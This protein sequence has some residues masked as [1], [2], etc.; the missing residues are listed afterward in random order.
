VKSGNSRIKNR[1]FNRIL[2]IKLRAIGDIVLCTPVFPNIKNAFPDSTVDVMVEEASSPLLQNNRFI[3]NVIVLPRKKWEKMPALKAWVQS[4]KFIGNLR[5]N[6]YDLIIDLFGNP[7]SAFLTFMTG[8]KTRVGFKFRGRSIFYNIKVDPRGDRVHEVE[9]N[10]DALRALDIHVR[11]K[12]PQIFISKHD[13]D[14]ARKWFKD[15]GLVHKK[16]IGIHSWASW[17]AKEWPVEKFAQLSDRIV[18][19]MNAEVVL[20]WGP[21]EKEHAEQI[22]SIAKSNIKLA[23]PT[24]LLQLAGLLECCSAVVATD[25]GPMHISAAVGTPTLGIYGPT[26]WKLQG[27]YGEKNRA[28]YLEGLD[29]LGCNLTECSKRTCMTELSADAVFGVLKEMI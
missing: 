4:L 11:D 22:R 6:N 29:C 17:K 20:L 23:P 19:E 1:K 14:F 13:S 10:L 7:R 2:V 28:V 26:N 5:K 9:F 21:G 8:C 15:N 12:F 24:T 27:P 18:K 16:V 3:D 25:S